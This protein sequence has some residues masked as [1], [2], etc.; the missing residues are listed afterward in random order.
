MKTE[1]GSL[2]KTETAEREEKSTIKTEQL[3]QQHRSKGSSAQRV[4]REE[5]QV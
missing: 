1:K 3:R 5:I 2:K 4:R